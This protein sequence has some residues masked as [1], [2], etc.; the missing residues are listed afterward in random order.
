MSSAAGQNRPP[1]AVELLER[2]I[3]YTRSSLILVT[4][5]DLGR[6]TPCRDWVLHDLLTHM[7]DALEA[8]AVAAQ[9]ASLSL[10]PSSSPD[11]GSDLLDSIC[12]RA[13]GLLAHWHPPEGLPASPVELG[14]LTLSRELLGSVGALEITL[15]GWDVAESIGRP[16]TI[17]PGLAMD[18]WPVARD[19][20]TDADRP[21]R[22]GEPV[23]VS[24]W[25]TPAARLLAQAGRS[26]DW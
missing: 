23:E 3:A 9:A 21:V 24:E 10:V 19:H 2:A 13:R 20:I 12:H 7:D 5:A 1:R 22:F 15:H 26:T 8:M 17:P 25:A 6:H 4:A 14:E 11:D 16:R 18:L